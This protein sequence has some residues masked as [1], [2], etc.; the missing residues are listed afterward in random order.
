MKRFAN[1]TLQKMA[2]LDHSLNSM[3]NQNSAFINALKDE[4][5]NSAHFQRRQNQ[6]TLGLIKGL[7]TTIK[8]QKDQQTQS[9]ESFEKM[10]HTIHLIA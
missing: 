7:S 10:K 1:E 8:K 5:E 6:D 4:V 9:Q 3:N 2:Q